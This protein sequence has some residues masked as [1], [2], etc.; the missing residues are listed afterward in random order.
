MEDKGFILSVDQSTAG[1]K[2][3]LFDTKLNLVAKATKNHKQ[4]YPMP[5]WVEHDPIEIVK[6]TYEACH[7]VL[8]SVPKGKVLAVSVTNQRETIV[9]WDGGGTPLYNAVVWQCQR[10]KEIC[11]SL[12]N[13]GYADI[14]RDKTGLLI[15]PYFSA[16][17]ITW[18]VKNVKEVKEKL[19]EG[20]S[21][22]GT[23]DSWLV[24]N[25]TKGK[26]H[27]T[28]YSNAS[29]TLLLNINTLKW[30][31]E[32]IDIFEISG[33]RLPA[34]V[35]SDYVVGYTDL[36]GILPHAVPILG[37]MGDSSASLYGQLGF[38]LGNTKAT[39]GTGTSIMINV[40]DTKPRLK[41]G[42]LSVGW[43]QEG[44]VDFV[45][46]GN[47]HSSGDT[48][49]W[50]VEQ[51]GLASSVEEIER[52]AVSV[53]DNDGVYLVPAFVGLG[54]PYWE[55]DARALIC[56]MSRRTNKSHIARAAIE[57][58]AYQVYDLF[59][60]L[61]EEAGVTPR[62]LRADGGATKNTF[63]MQFQ[64]DILNVPVAVNKFEDCSALGVAL[65]AAKK[66]GVIDPRN[67]EVERT[68]YYPKMRE[69]DREKCIRGWKEAVQRAI[70]RV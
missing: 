61:C 62:E 37:I 26:A 19:L 28:D 43:S 3:F 66:M 48:I 32:L 38:D 11:E 25:L 44:K 2:A 63:L 35:D 13:K 47:I 54:A 40:K 57:S 10:G 4:Y 15:D 21:Y 24:W 1:T 18:L 34:L 6:R 36:D 51:M 46:E 22:V 33:I 49:K 56:G 55:N 59:T 16:S 45:V 30:D 29:R 41:S 70:L 68:Y 69:V 60:A 7:E 27:V 52:L 42:V 8:H 20:D 12:R 5:G 53:E 58:I 31:E 14:V 39:Y 65:L 9:V 23:V 50:L 67:F 64:A 17:K